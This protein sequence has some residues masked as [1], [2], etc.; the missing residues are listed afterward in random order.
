MQ[1][2]ARGM[3]RTRCYG[4]AMY[5]EKVYVIKLNSN[6]NKYEL[7]MDPTGNNQKVIYSLEIGDYR[8][9]PGSRLD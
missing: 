8:A 7:Y 6:S 4:L 2:A 3:K 5:G 9:A 1:A